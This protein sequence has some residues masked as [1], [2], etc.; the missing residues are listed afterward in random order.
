MGNGLCSCHRRDELFRA[1]ETPGDLS[2]ARRAQVGML[3]VPVC[4]WIRWFNGDRGHSLAEWP[5]LISGGS[6]TA[7]AGSVVVHT[8]MHPD[9]SN[10]PCFKSPSKGDATLL[11]GTRRS[12]RCSASFPRITSAQL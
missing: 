4:Q 1:K 9:L 12:W 11:T 2:G 6:C 10:L 3:F 7:C 5:T 8:A